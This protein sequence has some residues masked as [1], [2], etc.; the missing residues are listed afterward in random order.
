MST[1]RRHEADPGG[2]RRHADLARPALRLPRPRDLRRHARPDARRVRRPRHR[3][4]QRGRRGQGD[5]AD[6]RHAGAKAGI[7]AGDYITAV[8]GE[9]IVLGLSVNEAVKQMRG[10]PGE[11]IT[12]TIAREKSDP[13]DVKLVREVI[14]AKSVRGQAGRRL[15]RPARSPASTRRPPTSARRLRRP[16]SKNPQV[17]GLVLDLRN[18]P[19]GLLDQAVGV[20]DLFLEGGEIVSPRGRDPRDVERYNARPATSPTACRSWC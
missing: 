1:G 6:G 2:H 18:N 9:P 3:G 17:K 10:K 4:H 20:S 8:N 11:T 13:F 19:G 12:L 14:K 15:R 5:L 16:A 7:K